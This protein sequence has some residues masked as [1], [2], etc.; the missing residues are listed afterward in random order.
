MT[1]EPD[2]KRVLQDMP[3]TTMDLD[4]T[5]NCVLAC[6]Y[7]FRGKKN[8]RRLSWEVGTRAI[9]WLIDESRDKKKLSIALFGGEPLMEFELIKRLVPY[10]KSQAARRDKTIHFSATTNCVLIN[11]EMI[12]FFRQY[13]MNFH[14]SID[15]GPE[16]Q[17]KHRH[18]ADGRGTSA[19]IEPVIRKIL[20][21][22]PNRTARMSV[23][24]DTV[25]RW[26]DDVLY[27][28]ELGYKNLAM[29]FIPELDWT[30]AQWMLM[31]RELR[32]ISD[33]C[34]ERYRQKSPIYMKHIDGA[35]QGIVNPSRR[36]SHCGAGRGYVLV[37]T[38]GTIYP[39][40]RF[41]GD[42]DAESDQN[43]RLGSIFEGW[44]REK[45][46]LLLDYDCTSDVQA[47]C[48]NCLAV[49]TCGVSCIAVNWACFKNIY[50]PHPNY[51]RATNLYFAEAMRIHYILE[52]EKN[53]LFIKKYHPE[54][55]RKGTQSAKNSGKNGDRRNTNRKGSRNMKSPILML[56]MM[57]SEAVS[58]CLN[59]TTNGRSSAER[60]VPSILHDVL[61]ACFKNGNGLDL[62]P[63]LLFDD[64]EPLDPSVSPLLESMADRIAVPLLDA[65]WQASL[66]IPFSR[67]QT[68]VANSL[69]DLV[70]GKENI[71]DR[72][73]IL[74]LE[75][76]EIP[77]LADQL[78]SIVSYI[79][80]ITF[81][82]RDILQWQENDVQLY[83]NQLLHLSRHSGR[84]FITN[85]DEAPEH[86]AQCLAGSGFIMLGPD[87]LVYPCPAFYH[88]GQAHTL[89]SI[90]DIGRIV[91][92]C[93]QRYMAHRLSEPWSCP[94]VEEQKQSGREMICKAHKMERLVAGEFFQTS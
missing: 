77:Y 48:E 17:D 53:D 2:A 57:S 66:R 24:N 46:R 21:Y 22:W 83:G 39:C 88:A 11:D 8:K 27:L 29:I 81:R 93:H 91:K 44:D 6:D 65:E 52:A 82:L 79:R 4:M 50:K 14:T 61:S 58:P 49:H 84:P 55:L 3:V 60:L 45:R 13:G 26:M 63:F 59:I 86:A 15:G 43:W 47:D 94:F 54:R 28:V 40:H 38:D 74:Y 10:A 76:A 33:Y 87:G 89:G 73:V 5:N 80:Q 67:Q 78:V 1:K 35:L 16:S 56:V 85:L 41:G 31:K 62:L 36:K 69:R 19:I 64:K 75:R 37:K 25:H 71:R 20:K 12:Q 72:N 51:C 9:D 23:S 18:F 90:K 34:I 7:C 32:K 68:A 30:E 70:A 42:I 92:D